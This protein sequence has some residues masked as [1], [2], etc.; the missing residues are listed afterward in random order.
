[1]QVIEDAMVM[2]ME[3]PLWSVVRDERLLLP[4][5]HELTMPIKLWRDHPPL[6]VVH[7][8]QEYRAQPFAPPRGVYENDE[9]RVEWHRRAPRSSSSNTQSR[10][11]SDDAGHT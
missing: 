2:A 3:R 11:S 1:V 4:P 9:I 10:V 5:P 7:F 6:T 8:P